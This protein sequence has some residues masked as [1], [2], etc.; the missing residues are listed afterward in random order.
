MFDVTFNGP[1]WVNGGALGTEASFLMYPALI[2]L[3]LYVWAR[4]PRAA[5]PMTA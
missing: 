2:A 4:Y 1:A 3:W 5:Q